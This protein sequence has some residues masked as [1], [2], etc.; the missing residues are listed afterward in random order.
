MFASDIVYK[1]LKSFNLLLKLSNGLW[2]CKIISFIMKS[3][4]NT[5]K[6]LMVNKQII[7]Q[8][9]TNITDSNKLLNSIKM[10][11]G[12]VSL[13]SNYLKSETIR[14]LFNI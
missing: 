13:Q 1:K 9:N 7:L 2:T 10:S 12:T 6:Q 5:N 4:V 3:H 8:S 11:I 14:S